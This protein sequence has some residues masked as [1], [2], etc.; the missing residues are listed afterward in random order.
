MRILFC[1]AEPEVM[2][3]HV[4]Q[5]VEI[6]YTGTQLQQMGHDVA[7]LDLRISS[8]KRE[9]SRRKPDLVF[10][11]TQ[12]YDRSQCFSLSFN[13][14]KEAITSLR[15]VLPEVPIV[16][17]GVHGSIEPDLTSRTLASDLIL[18]GE[19][20]AVVP[21]FIQ[22]YVRD[23]SVLGRS[24]PGE[25]MPQQVDPATLPVP[26][27]S[28][29]DTTA[30]RS[31][32]I[33]PQSRSIR[34][35]KAG[36]IFANRGCPFPCAYCFVWFG[37]RLRYRP[38]NLVVEELRQQVSHGVRHFFF[39]DYTFTLDKEWVRRL[40]KEIKAAGLD[41]S[42]LCQTRCEC[43][44]PEIL[45][46]MREAGCLGIFYGVESPWIE[47]AEMSKPSPRYV[48]DDVIR[49]TN[50]ADIRCFL[51]ILLGVEGRDPAIARQLVDWLAQT[52]AIFSA[53]LLLP[54]PHTFL[55]QQHS[56]ASESDSWEDLRA[57]SQAI[58]EEYYQY[59]MLE[60]LQELLRQLPNNILN[61][62]VVVDDG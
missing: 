41:I 7:V 13:K 33:D 31:E 19:L 62:P 10:L 23:S 48:I 32:V 18:P 2:A 11:L 38:V 43:V 1:I 24:L 55:W 21:W 16:T 20:E 58:A 59:S 26:N 39:L 52:P 51:F 42:W 25:L 40:C 28:L 53:R 22:E 5:P 50:A 54:R 56:S 60:K 46:V 8:F 35:A 45:A 44:D 30:Y 29:I 14:A 37:K 34:F 36:L 15:K 27:Y 47:Q 17:V 61:L 3:M 12:T 6:L 57:A 4:Q 9:T 49:A